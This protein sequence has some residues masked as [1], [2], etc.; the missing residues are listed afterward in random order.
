MSKDNLYAYLNN[1]SHKTDICLKVE[2]KLLNEARQHFKGEFSKIF[3]AALKD[4]LEAKQA[5]Q[6]ASRGREE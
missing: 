1:P 2:T 4:A 3:A 5:R 6:L